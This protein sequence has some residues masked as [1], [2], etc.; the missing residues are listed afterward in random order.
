MSRFKSYLEWFHKNEVMTRVTYEN[1]LET[2]KQVA[3]EK[4]IR[5]ETE[6]KEQQRIEEIEKEKESKKL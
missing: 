1:M 5:E 6:R 3:I 4:T 2:T